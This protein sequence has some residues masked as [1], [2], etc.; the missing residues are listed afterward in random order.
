MIC[1]RVGH[2]LYFLGCTFESLLIIRRTAWMYI[3]MHEY[4]AYKYFNERIIEGENYAVV[5][6]SIV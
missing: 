1:Q 2:E 6:C 3:R 4:N 5:I